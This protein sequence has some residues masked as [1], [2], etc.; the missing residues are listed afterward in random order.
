MV[1]TRKLAVH[2]DTHRWR[3]RFQSTCSQ[4]TLPTAALRHGTPGVCLR[5]FYCR[6]RQ[7]ENQSLLPGVPLP[8][9][10]KVKGKAR[11]VL[12]HFESEVCLFAAR[13]SVGLTSTCISSM[14]FPSTWNDCASLTSNTSSIPCVGR[15]SREVQLS[16]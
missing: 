13:E 9:G 16:I 8:A 7:L 12:C 3:P 4:K 15:Y 10:Q 1:P 5:Q 14:Y 2:N 6:R 11:A